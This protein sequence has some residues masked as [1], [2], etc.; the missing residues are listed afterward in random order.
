MNCP[1]CGSEI[2][3]GHLYCDNCGMEI[4]I[5]PDFEPEIENSIIETLSTMAEEIGT[6]KADRDKTQEKRNIENT[7]KDTKSKK[8]KK[9]LKQGSVSLMFSMLTFV[10][11]MIVAVFIAIMMYHTYSVHY[12]VN[13]AKVLAGNGD[14]TSAIDYLNKAEKLDDED[15]AIPLLKANYFYTCGETEKAISTLLAII[16]KNAYNV[17]EKEQTYEKLIEIY[18]A[19]KDYESIN[20]LIADCGDEAIQTTFQ[21][22]TA[23]KP[24]FSYS[25]GTYDEVIPL[26]LSSNTSGRIYF[27][28]DGSE[29]NLHSSVYTSPVFLES[30]EY[31]ISA[32]FV[33][34]YGI[35]SEIVTNNYLITLLTPDAPEVLLYSGTYREP[36]FLSVVRPETGTVYYTTDGSDPTEASTP[37]TTDIPMPLGQSNFKFVTISEEGVASDIV[38]RSFRLVLDSAVPTETAIKSIKDALISRN[39]LTDSEGHGFGVSGK[40]VYKFNSIIEIPEKGFYYLIYEYYEDQTGIQTKTEH[41]Y[42]VDIYSGSPNRLIYDTVGNMGLISLE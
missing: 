35:Q 4:R 42:A 9:E 6:E 19:L 17:E 14:Y 41:L 39:V 21:H 15:V 18:D 33:N 38:A 12:Q 24:E 10:L 26:K 28:M 30:G 23:K 37:Y 40:Y 31:T 20:E 25:G 13:R 27:T 34:D 2:V 11:V 32:F 36:T 3:D 5:V 22:Y 29:P 1:N 8:T 16:D 7:K